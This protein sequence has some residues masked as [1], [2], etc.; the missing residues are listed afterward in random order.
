MARSDGLRDKTPSKPGHRSPT[1]AH[2]EL[3]RTLDRDTAVQGEPAEE[4]ADTPR[5]PNA[6][7]SAAPSERETPAGN[8]KKVP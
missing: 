5:E 2:D 6:S 7:D 1:D 8:R 3:K 4:A